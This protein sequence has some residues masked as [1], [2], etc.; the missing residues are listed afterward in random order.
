MV[1]LSRR[2]FA[3]LL[4]LGGTTALIPDSAQALLDDHPSAR[5]PPPT[6]QEPDERFWAQIRAQFLLPDD[7]AFM[8]A[9]NLC[10][11]SRPV[12]EALARHT[13]TLEADPSPATRAT[14]REAREETRSLVA[15]YLGVTAGEIVL[16]RNTSEGNNFV[17]SGLALGPGDEVVTFSDNHP[18]NLRAWREKA[19]RFGFT[20]LAV[21]QVN[22][23]P[24]AEYYLDAFARALTPRTRVL[25]FTHVTNTTGDLFPAIELCHLARERGVL[26]LVDGAQALGVLAVDLA[27]IQPDFYTGSAHK[28]PCG[29]KETGFLYVRRDVHDAIAPSVVSLYPGAV[30]ISQKLEGMGQRDEPALA[31]LSEAIQFQT[32]IGRNAIEARARQLTQLLIEGLREVSGVTLWTHPDPARFSAVVSLRPGDL[33]PQALA[34]ALYERDRIVCAVRSTDDRPGIRLSP[35]CYNLVDEVERVV[36][37]VRTYVAKGV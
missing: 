29:P 22:P 19:D 2:R 37:A 15:A 3:H 35:H 36:S 9:A 7:L 25:A 21:D 12:V 23:H 14:L 24:G 16:T 8:N 13:R 28:W 5:P 27:A 34:A 1:P 18:S 26:T 17:S 6:P 32:A 30:G 33:D 31:A 4:A 11:A 10:P 20:V